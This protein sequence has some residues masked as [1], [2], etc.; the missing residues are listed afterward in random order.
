MTIS[1]NN[2]GYVLTGVGG[3][4]MTGEI[5]ANVGRG[6]MLYGLKPGSQGT[7][8]TSYS[9]DHIY[10]DDGTT[11]VHAIGIKKL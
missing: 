10:F 11:R 2:T 6:R 3:S 9:K 8:A 1:L 7:A 4:A 5:S